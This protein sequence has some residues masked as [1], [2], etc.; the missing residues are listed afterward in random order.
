MARGRAAE[1]FFLLSRVSGTEYKSINGVHS[2][3]VVGNQSHWPTLWRSLLCSL[4][5]HPPHRGCISRPPTTSTSLTDAASAVRLV[6]PRAVVLF[7]GNGGSP[8]RR[9]R[10]CRNEAPLLSDV[11]LRIL[12]SGIEISSCWIDPLFYSGLSRPND[13]RGHP[14]ATSSPVK[15]SFRLPID[16]PERTSTS[17]IRRRLNQHL[18]G[19]FGTQFEWW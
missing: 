8:F 15:S 17:V 13:R 14:L 3:R 6:G 11:L 10:R 18:N 16:H 12:I 4:L 9:R 5:L 19:I 7:F 1:P 2:Q